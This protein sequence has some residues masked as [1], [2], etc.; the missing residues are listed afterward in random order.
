MTDIT[1]SQLPDNERTP[2]VYTEFNTATAVRTLASNPQSVVLIAQRLPSGT[3]TADEAVSVFSDD[4]AALYFGRGSQAHLMAMEAIK[5]Y[6]YLQLSVMPV[7]DDATAGIAATCTL[8]LTGPASGTGQ[9]SVWIIGQRIDVAV[10]SATDATAMGVALAAAIN[11]KLSLPVTANSAAGVVTLTARNKGTWGNEFSVKASTTAPGVTVAVATGDAGAGDPDISPALSAVF[12]AGFTVVVTPFATQD[13]LSALRD[14]VGDVS[15]ALEQR[16][17][18]GVAGW[19]GTLSTAVTLAGDVNDGRITIGWHNGS[20]LPGALIAA[21][22]AAV[23]ASQT[24]PAKPYDDL[25]VS[26]LD[27]TPLSRRPGRNEIESALWN[28]VSPLKVGAGNQVQIVRA[29]STYTTSADGAADPSLLDITSMR[30][31][32]YVRLAINNRIELRFPQQKNTPRVGAAVRSEILNV[33]YQL[34][35]MEVVENVDEYKDGIVYQVSPTDST[36]LNFS[37]PV[38]I[39]SGLHVIASVIDM[40]L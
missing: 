13:A 16:G 5:A 6:R 11:A 15:S 7:D 36:R 31:L 12:A 17:T 14:F 10:A 28:G 25:P 29:I 2:G 24:D 35:D 39:V 27:V 23:I 3:W 40:I 30:T 34:E 8:T 20:Q 9:N 19:N 22:Y 37:I 1:F 32:D 33:L 18:T 26:G 4:Q 21:G 38:N